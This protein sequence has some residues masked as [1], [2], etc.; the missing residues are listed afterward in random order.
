MVKNPPAN[1]GDGGS[2]P[3]PG[4][5]LGKEMTTHSTILAWIIP[6]VEEPGRLQSAESQ[7]VRHD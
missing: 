1:A 2:I 5:S 4:R 3:V 7:R 6:S